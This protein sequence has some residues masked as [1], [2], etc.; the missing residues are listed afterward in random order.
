MVFG[1][2]FCEKRQI[3]VSKPHFG[4]VRVDAQ[5]WLMARWKAYG[6]LSIR[7]NL[8]FCAIY[9]AR[10]EAKCVQLGCFTGGRPLRTQIL[11]GHGYP[12]Q[13]FLA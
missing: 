13:P 12:H 8:N 3:W 7:I 4:K 1:R 9:Y 2:N 11:P 5:P 6:L 10:Y